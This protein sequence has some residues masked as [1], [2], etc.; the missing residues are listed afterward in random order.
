MKEHIDHHSI[1][2]VEVKFDNHVDFIGCFRRQAYKNQL[3]KC[4]DEFDEQAHHYFIY[5]DKDKVIGMWR[6]LRSDECSSLEIEK[7]INLPIDR[8]RKIVEI[9]RFCSDSSLRSK[10][11]SILTLFNFI[12]KYCKEDK[13]D[14]IVAGVKE[15]MFGI[16]RK[17]GFRICGE[18]FRY[19]NFTEI[20]YP[21]LM[22]CDDAY[23][24]PEN[25]RKLLARATTEVK[26]TGSQF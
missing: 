12:E 13:T 5:K 1:D 6:L 14:V 10:S 23:Q 24:F 17:I 7:E 21:M 16:Y 22:E 9:S 25:I 11:E 19:K 26:N 4:I 3:R 18:P 15:N 8:N 20:H 2:V